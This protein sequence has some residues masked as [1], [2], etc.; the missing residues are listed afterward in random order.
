MERKFQSDYVTGESSGFAVPGTA[1]SSLDAM[2]TGVSL[3]SLLNVNPPHVLTDYTGLA[4]PIFSLLTDEYPAPI[5]TSITDS[6]KMQNHQAAID[7]LENKNEKKLMIP[8]PEPLQY[9]EEVATSETAHQPF[10]FF[11]KPTSDF[12]D[13]TTFHRLPQLQSLEP[14]VS[15]SLSAQKRFRFDSVSLNPNIVDHS[16]VPQAFPLPNLNPHP[17]ALMMPFN[18][19]PFTSS[20]P[21]APAEKKAPSAIPQSK[22]ARRRRQKLSDKTRCLQKLMPWDKKMDMATMLG[23]AYKYVKFLQAQLYALQTMP[24]DSAIRTDQSAN[25][26]DIKDMGFYGGLERL[27]RNQV[28]Q[29]LVNSPVSQTMLYS[30]GCCVFS[31]EQLTLLNSLSE[32]TLLLRQMMMFANPSPKPFFN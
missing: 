16:M 15:E 18:K 24:S 20:V 10:Y 11:S 7:F 13:P 23:E 32:K 14:L 1:G 22:L 9:C 4:A 30:Q 21:Y 12:Y 31:V 3:Q 26:W 19:K 5:P 17:I 2:F 8:K 25:K 6:S 27:N 28:L 29:V